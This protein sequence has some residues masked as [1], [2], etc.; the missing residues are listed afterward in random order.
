MD[1][2]LLT[3]AILLGITFLL[4]LLFSLAH[5][6]GKKS[7]ALK[8]EA[9]LQ[10]VV[11][12]N[13]LQI[14]EKEET[15]HFFIGLDVVKGVLIYISYFENKGVAEVIDL[16]KIKSAKVDEVEN[17]TF[18]E[19]NGKSVVVDSQVMTVQLEITIKDGAEA[20]YSLPFYHMLYD[21]LVERTRLRARA[22]Y[23]KDIISN[24][25]KQMRGD[26]IS[27]KS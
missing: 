14:T 17:Q 3:A 16:S 13:N 8:R 5:K 9:K 20:R 18:E 6:R 23:W 26:G 22:E 25:L 11:K 2:T 27:I 21:S 10:D 19:R 1:S 7:D 24:N 15:A 12:N 4:I